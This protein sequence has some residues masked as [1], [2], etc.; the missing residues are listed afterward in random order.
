MYKSVPVQE[1][2]HRD[3]FLRCESQPFLEFSALTHITAL[4]A[5]SSARGKLDADVLCQTLWLTTKSNS[6]NYSVSC[7]V[8]RDRDW[9]ITNAFAATGSALLILGPFAVLLL[10]PG[11]LGPSARHILNVMNYLLLS[12][13]FIFTYK[14][15]CQSFLA[16]HDKIN[17]HCLQ[18]RGLK[19]MVITWQ[20][21][22]FYL[23]F[24]RWISVCGQTH[25][26]CWYL[27]HSR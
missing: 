20:L 1:P 10:S 3:D 15:N 21:H 5:N 22:T 16:S 23:V 11:F 25:K 24:V 7:R 9:L 12:S 26:R 6:S 19:V 17:L 14:Q 18:R 27:W 13:I 2:Q 4:P 8:D